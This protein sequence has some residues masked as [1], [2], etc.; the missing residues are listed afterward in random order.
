MGSLLLFG[1]VRPSLGPEGEARP[2]RGFAS[3]R[4]GTSARPSRSPRSGRG[5]RGPGAAVG[6]RTRERS[7]A[8]ELPGSQSPRRGPL[9]AE[10]PVAFCFAVKLG[11]CGGTF[12]LTVLCSSRTKLKI[13]G[14]QTRRGCSQKQSKFTCSVFFNLSLCVSI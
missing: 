9:G 7:A 10:V 13:L 5:R 3:E 4:E 6:C 11:G 1:L 8:R 12:G 14:C 2:V